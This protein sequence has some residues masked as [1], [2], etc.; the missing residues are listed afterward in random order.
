MISNKMF[1]KI[2]LNF[3]RPTTLTAVPSPFT[4]ETN[5]FVFKQQEIYH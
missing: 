4:T 2:I 5:H 3:N 1:Q